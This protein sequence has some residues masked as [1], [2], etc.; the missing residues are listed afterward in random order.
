VRKLLILVLALTLLATAGCASF[1]RWETNR[2]DGDWAYLPFEGGTLRVS[3]GECG[4]FDWREMQDWANKAY[5]EMREVWPVEEFKS[6]RIFVRGERL[7]NRNGYYSTAKN[8]IVFNC[9]V[10]EV[11]RHE[12]FHYYCYNAK[13]TGCDCYTID[14]PGGWEL[15]C[16]RKVEFADTLAIPAYGGNTIID[17]TP[18]ATL[19]TCFRE[20]DDG[21]LTWTECD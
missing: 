1:L 2:G 15:D 6:D 17:I 12:L 8:M 18:N 14:H 19:P 11:I 13:L 3:A 9:G 10:E 4:G 20:H 21:T 16:T 5:R 7:N